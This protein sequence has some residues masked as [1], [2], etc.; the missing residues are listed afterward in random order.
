VS[1]H[2]PPDPSTNSLIEVDPHHGQQL[3]SEGYTVLISNADGSITGE[4]QGLF[5]FDTR[6][7]SAYELLVDEQ[8]PQLVSAGLLSAAQWLA[9]L[10][11]PRAGG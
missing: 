4:R 5:D 1:D 7:L 2:P 9:R 6:V 11:L 10:T 8:R 3:A